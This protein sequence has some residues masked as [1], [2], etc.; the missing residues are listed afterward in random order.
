MGSGSASGG[1]VFGCDDRRKLPVCPAQK[2]S[3]GWFRGDLSPDSSLAAEVV[4]I[5]G[6]KEFAPVISA[7]RTPVPWIGDVSDGM[8]VSRKQD[9][10][11]YS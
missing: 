11:V 8:S 2:C 7:A 6:V 9:G 3:E 10:R 1:I 4:D 5:E